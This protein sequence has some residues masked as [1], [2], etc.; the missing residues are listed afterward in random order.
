M[1]TTL[2]ELTIDKMVYGGEAL[3]RLPADEHGKGKAVFLPFALPGER[4]HAHLTEQRP[5]FARAELDSVVSASPHRIEPRC[6]YFVRCGGCHYQHAAYEHQLQIKSDILRETLRRTAKIDWTGEIRAHSASP[7]GYRNR[8]RM[9]LRAAPE[10]AAGYY[11]LGTHDLLPVEQCPIS[12]PL[13]N[14]ALEAV[15]ELGRAGQV[16][17][18]LVEIEFFAD[19]ADTRMLV[20]FFATQ[21][22]VKETAEAFA[23]DLRKKM[24]EIAGVLFFEQRGGNRD[25]GQ[26]RSPADDLDSAAGERPF[27]AAGDKVLT[28]ETAKAKYRVSGGSFFQTN[29]F[30]T[31]KLVELVTEGRS[32]GKA[33]DLYAGVGLFATALA[34]T[35]D[36]VTAVESAPSSLSDLQ[37]N[38]PANVS[39]VQDRTELFLK[40]SPGLK[41]DLVV[42]DPPRAG[43][44]DAAA[45][46]LAQVRTPRITYVSCNPATLARDLRVLAAAGWRIDELNFIDLFPQTYHLESVVQLLK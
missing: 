6:P 12:S 1:I 10:F 39:P 25:Q 17:V 15:W 21:P 32:G 11:R 44:G 28:Y 4:V 5:G 46:V 3:A 23:A 22:P 35:F 34:A 7:W 27:A 9:R 36:K 26:V 2:M 13:I 14:R 40:N 20:A 19:A 43:L 38:G 33:L 42:I 8:T 41:A 29:R 37:C 18:Q 30:L 16:P 31:D 24:P 45:Q